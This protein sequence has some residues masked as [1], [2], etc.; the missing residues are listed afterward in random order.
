MKRIANALLGL[1][2]L[3]LLASIAAGQQVK[4]HNPK[5]SFT[6]YTGKQVAEGIR[7]Q[8]W[9]LQARSYGARCRCEIFAVK[10]GPVLK[11]NIEDLHVEDLVF[12][13]APYRY[14]EWLNREVDKNNGKGHFS[15]LAIFDKGGKLLLAGLMMVDFA[16]AD[17]F[18]YVLHY[19]Q[20]PLDQFLQEEALNP[21]VKFVV[22]VPPKKE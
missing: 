21:L 13:N 9:T 18:D 7:N 22:Y 19:K 4:T 8:G 20:E 6:E 17:Q 5:T 1:G 12:T 15:I 2:V 10:G 3:F 16:E 11:A 14:P